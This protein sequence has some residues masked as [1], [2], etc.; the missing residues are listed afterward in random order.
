MSRSDMALE[1][2]PPTKLLRRAHPTGMERSAAQA[3]PTIGLSAGEELCRR[4]GTP[5]SGLSEAGL[6][7]RSSA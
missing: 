5:R 7:A 4:V 2:P 6:V 1:L 3:E